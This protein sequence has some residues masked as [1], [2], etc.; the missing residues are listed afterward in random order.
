MHPPCAAA[1]LRI[2]LGLDTHRAQRQ[3]DI[4]IY[5]KVNCLR[6]FLSSG[7]LGHA[8]HAS[9]LGHLGIIFNIANK[10]TN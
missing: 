6:S 3:D 9:H 1:Q 7:H 10:Q 2:N 4:E 8:A 5:H